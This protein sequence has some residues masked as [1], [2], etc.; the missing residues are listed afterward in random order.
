M[1]TKESMAPDLVAPLH[2]WDIFSMYLNDLAGKGKR[3]S[4]LDIL[5]AFGKRN[6]WEIDLN[7]LLS[8]SYEALVLTDDKVCIQWVSEGFTK[9]TGYVKSEVLGRNPSFLHGENTTVTSRSRVRT[10]LF[11]QG[12]FSEDLIN[13]RKNGEEYVCRVEIHP[14]Y[15]SD[16]ILS[17]YLA[18]EHE[19]R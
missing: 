10:Q 11:G 13:Y 17:H 16:D 5:E 4:E 18:L 6:D 3:K 1:K 8:R 19:V 7:V 15:N 14:I 9:M 2:C 12:A